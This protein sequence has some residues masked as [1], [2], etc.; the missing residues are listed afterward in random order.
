M[1]RLA[2]FILAW[3]DAPG[4][5]PKDT[6]RA[7]R[8][9]AGFWMPPRYS[10]HVDS[11]DLPFFFITWT[12]IFF[13]VLIVGLMMWFMWRYSRHR[14]VKPTHDAATHNTPLEVMWSGIPLILAIVMFYL[15]FKGYMDMRIVPQNAYKINV[16]AQKWSWDFE[17]PNGLHDRELH[18]WAG[19]DVQLVMKSMDVLHAVFIPDFRVKQDVVPGK[20]SSLWFNASNRTGQRES[21]HLFCAEYCGKEHSNMHAW[22]VVHPTRA[23]YEAW[24]ADASNIHDKGMPPEA[25]GDLLYQRRGCMSCHLLDGT[26]KTGPPLNLTWEEV[27]D[28]TRVFDSGP[29][30]LAKYDD[31]VENYISESLQEPQKEIVKGFPPLMAR[32]NLSD[33]DIKAIIAFLKWM[34]ENEGNPFPLEIW[35]KQQEQEEDEQ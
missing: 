27:A 10:N 15:G 35:E 28:G 5:L 34:S 31:L 22:V 16:T 19:A 21:H 14:G 3:Q 13:F 26:I 12:S 25:I 33:Q 23:D 1:I 18:V 11:V 24:L 6:V 17:Y 32:T 20:F 4:D 30:D 9:D 29:I 2:S 7:P 8:D